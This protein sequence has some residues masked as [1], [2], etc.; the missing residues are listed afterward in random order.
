MEIFPS[1]SRI[2]RARVRCQRKAP[3]KRRTRCWKVNGPAASEHSQRAAGRTGA[4]A[5]DVAQRR[6]HP[7]DRDES[8]CASSAHLLGDQRLRFPNFL[9]PA[10]PSRR[11]PHPECHRPGRRRDGADARQHVRDRGRRCGP[12]SFRSAAR[13]WRSSSLSRSPRVPRCLSTWASEP[14]FR[15][16]F[17]STS[18]IS[19]PFEN[20]PRIDLL[21]ISHA[22]AWG[23]RWESQ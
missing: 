6:H 20:S 5:I 18:I 23:L 2:A 8:R 15:A 16:P 22:S 10:G 12:G 4:G 7:A 14:G 13:R 19:R 3:S 11:Y 17:P 21:A 1:A 9:Q